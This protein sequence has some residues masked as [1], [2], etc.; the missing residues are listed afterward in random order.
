MGR[1]DKLFLKDPILGVKGMQDEL[2]DLGFIYNPK[3]IRRLLR[4]MGIMAIYSKPNLSRLGKAKYIHPYLL[5][6]MKITRPNQVWVIDISYIPMRKGFMYL[7]AIIDVYS[8]FIVGW[9]IS[10]T[11]EKQT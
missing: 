4:K 11:L 6:N 9:Q 7:T 5:R 3:R 8:R 2:F 1:I 10:N